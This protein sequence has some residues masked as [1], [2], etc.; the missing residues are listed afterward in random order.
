MPSVI[1]N[2]TIFKGTL[3]QKDSITLD[4][5]FIGDI[6]AEEIIV[7]DNGNINGNGNI[8]NGNGNISGSSNNNN[9]EPGECLMCSA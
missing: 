1:L 2:D 5:T 7:K 6:T 9:N 8:I 3:S 4:G